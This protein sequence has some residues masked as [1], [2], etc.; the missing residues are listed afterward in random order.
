MLIHKVYQASYIFASEQTDQNMSSQ[1]KILD[2]AL[3]TDLN[4][5]LWL[6]FCINVLG[7]VHLFTKQ[8]ILTVRIYI[9]YTNTLCIIYNTGTN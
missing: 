7:K 6:E 9:I 8:S 1:L 5:S 3:Y 2:T 4:I